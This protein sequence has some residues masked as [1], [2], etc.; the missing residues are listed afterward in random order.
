LRGSGWQPSIERRTGLNLPDLRRTPIALEMTFAACHLGHFALTL[1]LRDALRS[2]GGARVVSVSSGQ[3][4][5]PDEPHRRRQHQDQ[6][7]QT[8]CA[9]L[10]P[11]M[12]MGPGMAL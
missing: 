2:A 9:M 10:N 3:P 1:G 7:D 4:K 5:N 8:E 6:D 12:S 11:A